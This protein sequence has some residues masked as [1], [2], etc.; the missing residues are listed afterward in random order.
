MK[1]E[2]C[3]DLG[4]GQKLTTTYMYHAAY[5]NQNI[6]RFYICASTQFYFYFPLSE[7]LEQSR[8]SRRLAM[9][10][11]LAITLCCVFVWTKRDNWR[12]HVSS[13][14]PSCRFYLMTRSDLCMTNMEKLALR[15]PVL[16]QG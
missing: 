6:P 14:F 8:N 4:V 16:A 3:P 5:L 13:I 15:V 7:N 2:A 1:R 10:M 12:E 11:R 9:H